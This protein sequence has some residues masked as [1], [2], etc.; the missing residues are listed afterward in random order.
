MTNVG[1][2]LNSDI[3]KSI[4]N[5][6]GNTPL[7]HL[8]N[9]FPASNINVYAKLELMNP[10][11]SMK[12]RPAEFLIKKGFEEGKINNETHLIE[13]SSGNLGIALALLSKF[14]NLQFTCVVDPKISKTNLKIIESM[15]ANISMVEE[16]DESG[17]YLQTRIKRVHE[18]LATTPNAYWINQYANENN[19][20]SHYYGT[21]NEIVE[22]L[23]GK[24]LDILIAPVSTSGSIM[25][26]S[27][28]LREAY[29]NLMVIA[30]DAVG[31]IIFDSPSAPR[32]LP[33]IGA[34]RVPELLNKDEIDQV[35]HVN[36]YDSAM[37]CREVLQKEG[38]FAGGS[39]GSVISAIKKLIPTLSEDT[40]IV[41]IF[42]DRGERYLDL[43]YDDQW[44]NKVK[45]MQ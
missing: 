11:G 28:R 12:D 44:L 40:N 18:L 35:I 4:Q 5:C 1:Q 32:E 25:G 8:N 9:L 21:G 42:P 3:T 17:G 13:S 29:P 37:A 39:S 20:K 7:F 26:I 10:G 36:D 33:G 38:I 45:A 14:H 23:G 27:R 30:V 2:T 31:S 16:R 41:T 22:Q 34:S 15:G 19:W 43:V 24:P 6:I